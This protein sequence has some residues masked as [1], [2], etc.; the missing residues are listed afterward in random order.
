M[1][2]NADRSNELYECVSIATDHVVVTSSDTERSG[3]AQPTEVDL[4]TRDECMELILRH[5][6]APPNAD[7]DQLVKALGERSATINET[8][9]TRAETGM[10]VSPHPG[11]LNPNPNERRDATTDRTPPR[12]GTAECAG[13]RAQVRGPPHRKRTRLDGAPHR[14]RE[15]SRYSPPRS[16]T[17]G[18]HHAHR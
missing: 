2:D 11:P 16:T 5:D 17:G 13:A 4:L 15:I 7:A 12:R 8:I 6:G 14:V 1:F 10:R 9:A 18:G 3:S